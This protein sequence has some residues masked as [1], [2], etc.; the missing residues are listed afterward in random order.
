M[1]FRILGPLEVADGG[2]LIALPGAQRALLALLL[3]S[4]NEVVSSDRLIEALWGEHSPES[5]RTAL[6]V[7]VS[8]LRKALG[9]AGALVVTRAP[10][11]VLQL[12]AA[13][14][15][16]ARFERLVAE[17]DE[18]DPLAAAAKL[19]EALAL[20]RGAPLADLAYESFAQPAIARLQELRLV[21]VE[22]RIDADL[23][24]GRHA[25][26]VGEL[27]LL[28]AEHPLRE[29][30]RAL[31]ML[32]LYRGGRQADALAVYQSAR[33]ELVQELGIEPS[34]SLRE[35]E[36][37]ILQQDPALKLTPTAP[38]PRAA[39]PPEPSP[40][41]VGPRHNL[42]A[43]VSSFVGRERE[44]DDLVRLLSSARMLT[45]AGAGGVGKTRLA[46][47]LADLVLDQW[48]DG[49][50][51]VDLAAISDP[52]LV[53]AKLASVF[54]VPGAPGRSAQESLLV[55]L[56]PRE[57]VVILDNCEHLVESAAIVADA[58][59][60]GC[61]RVAIV[62]TSREPLRIGG[63]QVYRVPSLSL[64]PADGQD[65]DR[66]ADSAAVRLFVD[67]ARQQRP[68][69]ALDTDN[70]GAVA[71][72]CRRLDG[73]PL[74]I[75][76]AAA[77]LRALAVDEIEK[78]LDQRFALLT[79][80][81]RAAL[82]RQQTLQALIDWSYN[83]LNTSEQEVLDRLSVF[84]GSFD[85]QSADAVASRVQ[86]ASVLDQVLALVDKSLIQWDDSNNRYRLLETVRDYAAAKL[87]ARG[88][89]VA[90]AARGAHRD[91]HLELA[92]TAAPHLI[93][94]G[95]AEWLDRLEL[96]FD[97]LRA[98]ISECASDPDPEAGLRLAYAL[99]YF[100]VYR[101]PSA[102]GALA[103]CAALDRADAQAPTLLRG[104][105]LVCAGHVLA[106]VAGEYDAAR[107]RAQ[108]AL[109]ISRCLSDD[110][111][112]AEA[113]CRL[114]STSVF[115][116]DLETHAALGK[117]SLD[118]A[119]MVSDPHLTAQ[120][121][122]GASTSP[123]VTQSERARALKEGLALTRQTGDQVLH[124]RILTALGYGAL[125]DGA[126]SVAR[127]YL[128]QAARLVRDTGDQF[129]LTT[130]TLNLGFA[131]YLDGTDEDARALFEEALRIAQRSGD[132][133]MVAHAQL[134][135]ALLTARAGDAISAAS[136][137]GTAAAI[138]AKLGSRFGPVESQLRDADIAA[139]RATLGEGDFE[140]AYN[141]G[142]TIEASVEPTLA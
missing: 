15:D 42:P 27:E 54:G 139:L 21:T 61:A 25:E 84:A 55:A 140:R 102:E 93:G 109:T 88:E 13:Q 97:N 133:Y 38:Q 30:L 86:E 104:R 126:I 28:V 11:Y 132:L 10:G 142:R 124:I 35:L 19:S 39:H 67:R 111:L 115:V 7:R 138:L 106:N 69:F 18:A 107:A 2:S 50:W 120:I 56:R 114:L 49:V 96:E 17:A 83:L 92:E 85:L 125:D 100:W 66:L 90:R 4:V 123:R 43:R 37:A 122:Y 3:L 5:G 16:L 53:A 82:P 141:T 24:L 129:G 99:R 117:E 89:T 6:Q 118:A 130:C 20:W 76:L 59:I 121:L 79:D 46:L 77:R 31:L 60:T 12:D 57:L 70:Y 110:R 33:R 68:G 75:E 14:L 112:R 116:G 58:L 72:L 119:S 36:Q 9:D 81:N 131:S 64:P 65:V 103:V 137:H 135:L 8:Q 127:P 1:E 51:F 108:E 34:S 62:A 22:K 105:A 32:A 26:L 74:A 23:T 45:L 87:L 98:A 91:Y 48:S 95:Q 113:L 134:G 47:Q 128:E 44:L 40:P 63:E 80:G 94:H 78:R 101:E 41:A 136:L 71:R 29:H 73:I 52:T